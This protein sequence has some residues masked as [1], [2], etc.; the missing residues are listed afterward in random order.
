MKEQQDEP[1]VKNE[2]ADAVAVAKSEAVS[3][4]K[5]EEEEDVADK[6]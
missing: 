5:E 3:P 4:A 6:D 2:A 1:E